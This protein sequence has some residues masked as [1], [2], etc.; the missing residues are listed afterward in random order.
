MQKGEEFAHWN[1]EMPS[2]MYRS[3]MFDVLIYIIANYSITLLIM[4]NL[5]ALQVS[6]MAWE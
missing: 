4:P 6:M 5:V 2:S 3:Q 1:P